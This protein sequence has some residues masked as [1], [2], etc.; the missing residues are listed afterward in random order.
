M[1][2]I[3]EVVLPTHTRAEA[4]ELRKRTLSAAS[5]TSTGS[6]TETLNSTSTSVVA[7]MKGSK[8][9]KPRP[10]SAQDGPN[11]AS[12][13]AQQHARRLELA[14]QLEIVAR[15]V[16]EH[17]YFSLAREC[18]EVVKTL[19][20]Q[21]LRSK[22]VDGVLMMIRAGRIESNSDAQVTAKFENYTKLLRNVVMRCI[23]DNAFAIHTA[24]NPKLCNAVATVLGA[25]T[26]VGNHVLLTHFGSPEYLL[27]ALFLV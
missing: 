25:R 13:E 17:G 4:A 12:G 27:F 7:A 23:R 5:A 1:P 21:D 19:R 26:M 14:E 15:E 22:N 9:K 20:D 16:T 8:V 6:E 24:K 11:T 3:R 10:R 18:E 2:T